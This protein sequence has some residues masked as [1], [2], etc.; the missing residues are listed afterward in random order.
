MP[1]FDL[2]PEAFEQEFNPG[3]PS[4]APPAVAAASDLG[5]AG[6]ARAD[7][8]HAGIA[9][10]D[11]GSDSILGR[12]V[13]V[14]G[15]DIDITSDES[16]RQI[17]WSLPTTLTQD[18]TFTG[19]IDIDGLLSLD[20]DLDVGGTL[21]VDTIRSFSLS[22]DEPVT[23]ESV[24]WAAQ[25]AYVAGTLMVDVIE[26]F[27]ASPSGDLL[28]NS[29]VTMGG[30]L[31]AADNDIRNVDTLD[32]AEVWTDLI[33]PQAGS[34]SGLVNVV[35]DFKVWASGANPAADDDAVHIYYEIFGM[36]GVI[37]T[38]NGD[39]TLYPEADL[40]FSRNGSRIDVVLSGDTTNFNTRLKWT[41]SGSNRSWYLD[42]FGSDRS[43]L[44]D[45]L[46]LHDSSGRDWVL[47]NYDAAFIETSVPLDALELWTDLIY[48]STASPT[49]VVNIAA[50]LQVDGILTMGDDI[51]TAGNNIL[52]GAGGIGN[53][54]AVLTFATAA[55]G[56]AASFTS[57]VYCGG[58]SNV[59]ESGGAYLTFD[60]SNTKIAVVGGNVHLGT[61]ALGNDDAVL[62]FAAGATGKATF[63][64]A[65]DLGGNLAMGGN[66]ITAIGTGY[67]GTTAVTEVVAA[68]T[69]VIGTK[70]EVGQW[71]AGN[72]SAIFSHT[73]LSHSVAGNYAFRQ[74]NTG[75]TYVNA[76]TGTYVTIRNNNSE[77]LRI[78]GS[79][80]T[81]YES[82]RMS[83][84]EP[85]QFRDAQIYTYSRADGFMT[86][87][88]DSGIEFY[89]G[90]P[91]AE[92]A[93]IDANGLVMASGKDIWTDALYA[94]T[95]ESFS[96][97][98][99]E[100]ITC[101]SGFVF[102]PDGGLA[103]GEIY[104]RD[105][106]NATVIAVAG[107]F[108]QFTEF[109][110]D[111]HANL[112]TPDHTNDHITITEAGRY[113]VT[114]SLSLLSVGGGGA[115]TVEVEVRKNNGATIFNN[116]H[117]HR[118]LAGGGGDKGSISISGIIDLAVNDTVEVWVANDDST[119]NIVLEDVTLSLVQIGG[120]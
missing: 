62:T 52:L 98:P 46:L 5:R 100:P 93:S 92:I 61:N 56:G 30:F 120:T 7:H 76:P 3:L 89:V 86:H 19:D 83:T 84:T 20:G 64:G 115:D 65:V 106:V 55:G 35:S 32:A 75:Y 43:S 119:D 114:L 39:L 31:D 40:V 118:T 51:D 105:N 23:V 69:V 2:P 26:P 4:F 101:Q 1:E 110:T 59:G 82:M 87:V 10:V 71:P 108:V 14:E 9:A 21:S 66:N 70:A 67:F 28:L 50:G 77:K 16:T 42:H 116:L 79:L 33:Y 104:V 74:I 58:A 34:P 72:T 38:D 97:S 8:T 85:L 109:N 27:S 6:F 22:P 91:A 29:D 11:V 112:T 94:D 25:D 53:D 111:G 13:F 102:G 96:S 24:L 63:T 45:S 103:Y 36:E 12:V 117:S 107:T 60:G 18:Y 73:D 90:N 80:I 113:L 78:A 68:K 57:H 54:S 48:P 88:A 47:F 49:G 15:T 17:T 37:A 44:G 41:D 99:G 81:A 95:I